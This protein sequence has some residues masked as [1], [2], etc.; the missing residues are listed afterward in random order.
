MLTLKIRPPQQLWSR[1]STL[2]HVGNSVALLLTAKQDGERAGAGRRWLSLLTSYEER[3]T[4]WP[5]IILKC[6]GEFCGTFGFLSDQI[7][8]KIA[9]LIHN[10]VDARG[11]DPL[12][13]ST[14]FPGSSPALGPRARRVRLHCSSPDPTTIY[15]VS[16]LPSLDCCPILFCR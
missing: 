4:R 16:R 14:S 12:H 2:L 5:A 15:G 11:I 9:V 7:C 10:N 6:K 13:M 8:T 3:E 1:L